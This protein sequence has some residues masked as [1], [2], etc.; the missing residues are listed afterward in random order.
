MTLKSLF[1]GLCLLVLPLSGFTQSLS[2]EGCQFVAAVAAHS[3]REAKKL[4][5]KGST[6]ATVEKVLP[7][8]EDPGKA[9]ELIDSLVDKYVKQPKADEQKVFEFE[10]T[11][12]LKA[13]G[14]IEKLLP[15]RV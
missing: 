6:K 7:R 8:A 4:E 2:A 5:P 11:R 10:F 9:W 1:L 14:D 15:T 13:G 3:V 12:C